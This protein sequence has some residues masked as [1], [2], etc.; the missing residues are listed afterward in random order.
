MTNAAPISEETSS[1]VF[2]GKS[3]RDIQPPAASLAFWLRLGKGA[4]LFGGHVRFLRLGLAAAARCSCACV[5][6]A[7]QVARIQ[8]CVRL[9]D[10]VRQGLSDG[11]AELHDILP[12]R[13]N[14]EAGIAAR[15]EQ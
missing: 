2:M 15:R 13:P 4:G 11:C 8:V 1:Q 9:D 7:V 14:P 6:K 10:H 5:A 12:R 3:A